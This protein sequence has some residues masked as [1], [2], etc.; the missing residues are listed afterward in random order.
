MKTTGIVR[1]VDDLGRVVI[2]NEIRKTLGI[3]E[4][5][6]MEFCIKDDCVVFKPYLPD[7]KPWRMLENVAEAIQ[8]NADFCEF[9]PEI[10]AIA[11]RMKQSADR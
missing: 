10:S 2:P 11:R 6:P 8:G 5:D 7:M 9:A 4:N 3:K 1:R